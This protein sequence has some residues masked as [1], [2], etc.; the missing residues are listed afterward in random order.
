[1][2]AITDKTG[3][4]PVRNGGGVTLCTMAEAASQA[5]AEGHLWPDRSLRQQLALSADAAIEAKVLS[6]LL[7]LLTHAT[8]CAA[9]ADRE[10][11]LA[12]SS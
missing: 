1:M 12:C 10:S 8:M 7:A 4:I 6:P 3:L 9:K 5:Q 11:P 2:S